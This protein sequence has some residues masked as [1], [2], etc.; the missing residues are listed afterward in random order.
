VPRDV[1]YFETAYWREEKARLTVVGPD[2]VTIEGSPVEATHLELVG[3]LLRRDFWLDSQKR[4]LKV[5][6]G[7]SVLVRTK[8][9]Q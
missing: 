2:S 5:S 6:R 9:P 7:S 3:G 4:L 8:R 1:S